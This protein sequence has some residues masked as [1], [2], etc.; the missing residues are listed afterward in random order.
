M[1]RAFRRLR[2]GRLKRR[3]ISKYLLYAVGEI[4]LVI[5]GILLA[6]QVDNW[7]NQRKERN[8]LHATL[9]QVYTV[10]DRDLDRLIAF[11]S[12]YSEQVA[13]IDSILVNPRGINP[14]LLPHMLYYLDLGYGSLV[15]EVSN[16][17]RD[18]KF[19]PEDV[20]QRNLTKAISEYERNFQV[21][22]YYTKKY[23]TPLLEQYGISEPTLTF[24]YSNLK[25][26]QNVDRCFFD[27]EEIRIVQRLVDDPSLRRT[28][29]SSRNE[30]L[31]NI[32][33]MQ[34]NMGLI[35]AKKDAVKDYYPEVVLLYRSMGVIGD[36]TQLNSW[37]QDV[38]L[39][40]T[41]NTKAVWEGDVNLRNGFFKFRE[42]ADW[43]V[44]WGGKGF[45]E[46]N[47][48]W[49]GDNIEVREGRYHVVFNLNDRSYRFT[50]VN[51]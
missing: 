32:D 45:P 50:K 51:P 41:D 22:T 31:R 1:I 24:Q 34:F 13:M 11:Q 12:G 7:N 29:K 39:L 49:Y 6:I 33:I 28:L 19:D 15:T 23:L 16:L 40:P 14:K 25:N 37:D 38:E 10:F 17:V 42:G 5:I 44:N 36:G 43:T 30:K 18:L 27:D 47:M 3:Q 35:K 26:F 4:A 8:Q 21:T 48:V 20:Q 46:G 2:A 9:N